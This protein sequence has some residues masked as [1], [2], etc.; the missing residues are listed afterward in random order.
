ML[1]RGV[2]GEQ[3]F[4]L[5][6][7]GLDGLPGLLRAAFDA[8]LCYV[9]EKAAGRAGMLLAIAELCKFARPGAPTPPFA[10]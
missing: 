8:V 1:E 2:V 5:L 9:S 7:P 4:L 3:R 10:S 6:L